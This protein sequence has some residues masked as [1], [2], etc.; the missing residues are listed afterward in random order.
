MRLLGKFVLKFFTI[1]LWI[2]LITTFV[3]FF[4]PLQDTDSQTDKWLYTGF[5]IL[6]GS[7][8]FSF[9]DTLFKT[10]LRTF[11]LKP[12]TAGFA[13]VVAFSG[14]LFTLYSAAFNEL[15][16]HETIR[17]CFLVAGAGFA[18]F[19]MFG[20]PSML[21]NRDSTENENNHNADGQQ[22]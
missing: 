12:L 1:A 8:G 14:L 2:S 9:I 21:E 18:I 3:W 19:I 15:Q 5:T 17:N 7:A 13:F 10:P 4:L 22:L 20:L 11:D 16:E 6:F